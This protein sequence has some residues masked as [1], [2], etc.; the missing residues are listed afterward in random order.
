MLGLPNLIHS[1][2]FWWRV[3]LVGF[4]ISMLIVILARAEMLALGPEKNKFRSE[5]LLV[6]LAKSTLQWSRSLSRT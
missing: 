1:T 5:F 6:H 3:V 4:Q 2:L